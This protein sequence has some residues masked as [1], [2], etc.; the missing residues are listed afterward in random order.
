MPVGVI[1][2]DLLATVGTQS[3]PADAYSGRL[4]ASD[5]GVAI[6]DF[7]CEVKDPPCRGLR[8]SIG[9]PRKRRFLV[10]QNQMNLCAPSL[11]PRPRKA[12]HRP[13][14]LLHPEQVDIKIGAPL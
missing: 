14:D 11:K 5:S 8:R 1:A 2:P 3:G 9:K 7:E 4:Q 10:F 12:K 13:L 6:G